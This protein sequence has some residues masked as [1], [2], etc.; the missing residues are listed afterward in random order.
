[1]IIIYIF[2]IYTSIARR[3]DDNSKTK[4]NN[5]TNIINTR[6]GDSN[7]EMRR[8]R[9]RGEPAGPATRDAAAVIPGFIMISH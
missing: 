9:V 2:F 7:N 1:M 4:L 5:Q 3:T 6:M 8:N